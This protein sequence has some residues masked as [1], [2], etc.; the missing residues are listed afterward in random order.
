[1]P[2]QALGG[3]QVGF[4]QP[5]GFLGEGFFLVKIRE[6]CRSY[7]FYNALLVRPEPYQVFFRECRY[8]GFSGMPT[9]GFDVTHSPFNSWLTPGLAT[10]P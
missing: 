2:V 5:F 6:Q 1:M 7:L 3:P 10:P 8:D 4:S 9:E